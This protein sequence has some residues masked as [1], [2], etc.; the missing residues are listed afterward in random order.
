MSD[1]I[2]RGLRE[3]LGRAIQLD[4]KNL[5]R[6]ACQAYL[7]ASRVLV[8]LS[9]ST[10]IPSVRDYYY[11]RAE[12]CIQRVKQLSGVTVEHR[13]RRPRPTSSSDMPVSPASPRS[14]LATDSAETRN[15]ME[16]LEDTMVTE[17][18][19]VRL[20][21]V[22][23]LEMAKQ[24]IN[25]A[26]IVPMRYPGL[27]RGRARQP[28]RGILLYGPSGCGKTMIAK[29]VAAEI[30]ATFFNV[31]AANIVSKWLGE[32]ERLVHLLFAMARE[33]QPSIIFVDEI[34]SIGSLRSSDDV[35][36]ERRLKTQLL[37]ELQ[38]LNSR[39][40]ERVTVI[41]ATNLPWELDF[42]LLSRFE[43]RILVPLPD[44]N[45][46]EMIFRVHMRDVEVAADVSF[47]DLADLTEGYS[48][49]DISVICREAAME[50]IRELQRTGQLSSDGLTPVLRPVSMD[51]FLYA[52][53]LTRPAIRAN[54]ISRYVSWAEAP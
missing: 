49:R 54:D 30:N 39:P 33:R 17:R 44:L 4:Q 25:D 26:V 3:L 14:E 12:E 35:G 47:R 27:F 22:A 2:D 11:R 37:T 46:R 1:R 43:K 38:G 53:D 29:A 52:I 23:G 41:A 45:A 8:Q 15:L 31:S 51:D 5:A 6:E 42:A 50:P 36:G 13:A 10:S 34:D 28:W 24:A 9:R 19:N 7:Q 40:E 48:G 21:D 18:P 32:S 20:T 16:A